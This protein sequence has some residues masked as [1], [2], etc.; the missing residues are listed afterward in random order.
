MT[1]FLR[2]PDQQT[3]T[4]ACTEAGLTTVTEDGEKAINRY[5]HTHAM[6]V[7][8]TITKVVEEAEYD[9]E[10]EVVKEAVTEEVD[11]WH[12]NFKGDLPAAF[13]PYVIDKPNKPR[14][15]FAGDV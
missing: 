1:T 9:E 8:G 3:F 12:V 14:E 7:I 11:G 10:G 5:S 15:I 13:E 2:F 4:D 6:R